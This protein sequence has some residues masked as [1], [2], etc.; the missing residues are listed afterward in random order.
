MIVDAFLYAGET[1]MLD[2]RL[3]T[4]ADTVDLFVPVTSTLTHQGHPAPNPGDIPLRNVQPYI[5]RPNP[6]PPGNRGG[7]G[8][9]VYQQIER[10]HR[11]GVRDAVI[12]RLAELEATG[13]YSTEPIVMVSDVDEIPDPARVENLPDY[14][15][16]P[17][18]TPPTGWVV[19]E[20]RMHSGYLE[21]LHPH[22]PWLG[23][24]V[25]RLADLRPQAMRDARG[26]HDRIGQIPHGGW[27]LSWLG[28]DEQRQQ[29]LDTFSHAE[30][31]D[32]YDP[33]GGRNRKRHANGEHLDEM[34]DDELHAGPW[35][36]PFLDSGYRIPEAWIANR[37]RWHDTVLW[38]RPGWS[39]LEA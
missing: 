6:N 33:I 22:Q 26:Q 12:V 5:V 19:L 39:E 23:T 11:D 18:I 7:V 25:A 4:L 2:L 21:W 17:A 31:R 32:R 20:Q 29:K 38:H 30:L 13:P 27:H 16:E 8:S 34:T 1:D 14:L 36:A 10:E 28:T 15:D 9:D 35:P 37:D 24:C 3:R